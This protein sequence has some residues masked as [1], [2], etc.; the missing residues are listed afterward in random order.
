MVSSSC[1]SSPS[2]SLGP[3]ATAAASSA[4]AD[5]VAAAAA[6]S[7]PSSACWPAAS[8]LMLDAL[9]AAPRGESVAARGV[10][11][12]TGRLLLRPRPSLLVRPSATGMPLRRAATPEA[13]VALGMTEPCEAITGRDPLLRREGCGAGGRRLLA[14]MLLLPTLR[15]NATGA[16]PT[17]ALLAPPWAMTPSVS[18]FGPTDR[19]RPAHERN[20]VP[21]G[22][23]RY[24][25][26]GQQRPPRR[27]VG[28]AVGPPSRW[29]PF[30]FG[31]HRH[32]TSISFPSADP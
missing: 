16:G 10:V 27:P 6:A 20:R 3:S 23:F 26:C 4:A 21:Y 11:L 14:L 32:A 9:P 1:S 15:P 25:P 31:P 18:P 28:D 7:S 22:L 29:R 5:V 30:G 17:L 13:L 2:L 19:R 12:F 24:V 8:S